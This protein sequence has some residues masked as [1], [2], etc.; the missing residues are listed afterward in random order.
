MISA[1]LVCMT[2]E[3]T[4]ETTAADNDTNELFLLERLSFIAAGC[5]LW[6]ALLGKPS[7]YLVITSLLLVTLCFG[8]SGSVIVSAVI[9]GLRNLL[10]R[11]VE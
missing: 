4:E 1:I 2:Q 5:S 8:I 6:S 9:R 11:V 10:W 3:E 7:S